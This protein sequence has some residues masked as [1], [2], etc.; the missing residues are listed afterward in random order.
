MA[1]YK[2]S[3]LRFWFFLASCLD[4]N[5]SL[6]TKKGLTCSKDR[7]PRLTADLGLKPSYKAV[8]VHIKLQSSTV[9]LCLS[10]Y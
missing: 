5:D 7:H 3:Q 6:K 4:C 2:K 9:D 8:N 1:L 10:L